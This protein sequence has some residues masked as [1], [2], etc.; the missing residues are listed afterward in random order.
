MLDSMRL[1]KRP[2]ARHDGTL[3]KASDPLSEPK[4]FSWTANL[5]FIQG[6]APIPQTGTAGGAVNWDSVGE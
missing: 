1:G 2:L 6:L 3:F 4:T 5:V